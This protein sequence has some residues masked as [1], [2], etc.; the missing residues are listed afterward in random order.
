MDIL[1]RLYHEWYEMHSDIYPEEREIYGRYE[2]AWDKAEQVLDEE[3]A[4]ELRGSFI[5]LM[6]AAACHDFQSG[7]RMGAQL[8]LALREPPAQPV[9]STAKAPVRCPTP[10]L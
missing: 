9:N 3:L 1:T 8:T 7:L 5:E 4:R 2:D 6:D 10:I